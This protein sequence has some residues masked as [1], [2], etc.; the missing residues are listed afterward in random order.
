MARERDI[1]AGALALAHLAI[2][3]IPQTVRWLNVVAEKARNH[4]PDQGYVNSTNLKMNFM[5]DPR[6]TES[7]L[8]EALSRVRGD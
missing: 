7:P 6:V 5:A 3:D 8:A 2:D 1:G 4:E